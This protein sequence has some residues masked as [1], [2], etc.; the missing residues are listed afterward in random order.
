MIVSIDRQKVTSPQ[1]LAERLRGAIAGGH[2]LML[3]N[4]HGTPQFVGAAP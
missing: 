2:V 4:R 3:V 1:D